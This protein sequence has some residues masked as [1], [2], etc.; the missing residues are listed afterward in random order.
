MCFENHDRRGPRKLRDL[1]HGFEPE[2]LPHATRPF[3]RQHSR[4]TGDS[5]VGLGL[6]IVESIAREHAATLQIANSPGG[7]AQVCVEFPTQALD[8]TATRDG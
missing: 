2:F 7:G 3:S 1:A 4:E 5:G 8:L 6:A